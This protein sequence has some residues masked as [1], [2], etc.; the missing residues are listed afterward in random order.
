MNLYRMYE[1]TFGKEA[2]SIA[3]IGDVMLDRYVTCEVVGLSPE[4]DLAHKLRIIGSSSRIGGAGNVAMN[5]LAL[6]ANV[7]LFGVYGQDDNG[8][9]LHEALR[10]ESFL[11][12]KLQNFML[13]ESGGGRPTT[14]KTRYLTSHGHHIVRIDA[15]TLSP[16]EEATAAELMAEV[17]DF[18][19]ELIV[20]SDYAKGTITDHLMGLIN[21]IDTTFI[22]DPKSSRFSKYGN[23]YIITPNE[24]EWKAAIDHCG[25]RT[26]VTMAERGAILLVRAGATQEWSQFNSL[27]ARLRSV[28]DPAGCGDSLIAG[29]AFGISMGWPLM[30]SCKFGVAAGSCAFDYVGVHAV[31][32]EELLKELKVVYEEGTP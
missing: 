19:P 14:T 12:E 29:L 30:D 22:V 9:A 23:P 4:Y 6:G 17:V 7:K 20:V 31:T 5:L 28:G 32:R 10:H 1:D 21:G 25:L 11:H 13:T 26:L 15:E 24:K 16:I 3:V 18:K 27:G 2:P 8:A